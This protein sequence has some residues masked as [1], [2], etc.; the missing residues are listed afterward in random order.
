MSAAGWTDY[1]AYPDKEERFENAGNP[2][3]TP[4]T[5]PRLGAERDP[6]AREQ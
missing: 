4:T 6:D 3:A 2:R 5:L 1:W